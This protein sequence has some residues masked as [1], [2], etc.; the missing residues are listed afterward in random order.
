M[1]SVGRGIMAFWAAANIGM[2]AWMWPHPHP[3]T[4]FVAAF[5]TLLTLAPGGE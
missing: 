4:V 5:L 3:V 1:T 2:I